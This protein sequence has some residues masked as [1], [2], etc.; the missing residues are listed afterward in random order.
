MFGVP[1]YTVNR[2]ND[3]VHKNDSF[4]YMVFLTMGFFVRS[5]FFFATARFLYC[6][7]YFVCE[8]V[9]IVSFF[10]SILKN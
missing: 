4:E 3:I 8:L 7:S 6:C 1:K 10:L 2:H 9:L 5:P